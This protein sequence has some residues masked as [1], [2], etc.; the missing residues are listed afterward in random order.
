MDF[1]NLKDYQNLVRKSVIGE[2][3][4]DRKIDLM[5]IINMLTAGPKEMVQKEHI[6]VEATS[7]GFREEEVQNLLAKLEEENIIFEA[8]PGYIKKR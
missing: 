1:D 4:L 5:T 3:R 2:R 8:M 7:R 6:I